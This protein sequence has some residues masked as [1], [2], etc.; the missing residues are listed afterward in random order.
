MVSSLMATSYADVHLWANA[1]RAAGRDH[2]GA[3][4]D[5]IRFQTCESPYGSIQVEPGTQHLVQVSR[6]GRIESRSRAE[7]TGFVE[8]LYNRWGGRWS[9]PGS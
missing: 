7:W 8:S 9:N 5:A 2:A 3:I 6:V 1:V 4:R